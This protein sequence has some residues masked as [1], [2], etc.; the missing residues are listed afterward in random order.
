M[1]EKFRLG[2]CPPSR[3]VKDGLSNFPASLLQELGLIYPESGYTPFEGR[4][5]FPI[6][7]ILGKIAGFGGRILGKSSKAKYINSP[8][9]PIYRK[10]E[11]LYGLWQ[12]IESIVSKRRA[13][14]VEGYMDV[15]P[16]HRVG[17]TEAVACCGTAITE[18]QIYILKVL[19][20]KVISLFDG[21][22]AG[23]AAAETFE[24]FC[25]TQ[26]V[27]YQIGNLAEGEDPGSVAEKGFAAVERMLR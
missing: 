20:V 3:V 21:D 18:Y 22:Q 14:L 5:I 9:S 17:F 8:E 7:G 4:L 15:I 16:L 24:Q 25:K 10:S 12:G 6:I 27:M 1:I 26:R 19:G 23:R 2:Y 11:I 13:I